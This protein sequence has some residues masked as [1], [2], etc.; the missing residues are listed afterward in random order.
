MPDAAQ[1][2]WVSRVLGITV[3]PPD[4][5]AIFAARLTAVREDM[6]LYKA[7]A[8]LAGPLREAA[9]A[10]K[11]GDPDA[12]DLVDALERRIAALAAA[13][14][15]GDVMTATSGG[16]G[17]VAFAKLRLLLRELRGEYEDALE[18]LKAACEALLETDAFIDDPRSSDPATL[19]A[20]GKLD[21]RV[22]DIGPLTDEVNAAL[23]RMVSMQDPG[24]RT[25]EA[26]AAIAAITRFRTRLDGASL[27]KEMENTDAG[28]FQIHTKMVT[29]LDELVAALRE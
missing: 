28:S 12:A 16:L 19:T 22:P 9:L 7:A 20:I 6:L 21:T 13:S 14:R 29:V 18:N 10:V 23:D 26:R 25:D 5:S 1:N 24:K 4:Q 3:T 17:P 15:A 8:E 2:T 11:S 27:L